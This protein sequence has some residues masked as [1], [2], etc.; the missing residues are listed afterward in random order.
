MDKK[1]EDNKSLPK[2]SFQN[3]ED[4]KEDKNAEKKDDKI[5]KQESQKA[6]RKR[7]IKSINEEYLLF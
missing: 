4:K 5:E 3:N 7:R 6:K 2:I 1:E